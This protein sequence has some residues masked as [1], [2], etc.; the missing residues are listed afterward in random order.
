MPSP[1]K[2]CARQTP[3]AAASETRR[4]V[5]DP[6]P[7]PAATWLTMAK[8]ISALAKAE[9]A[10][11]TNDAACPKAASAIFMARVIPSA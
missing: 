4:P 9:T 6:G 2:S 10:N 8:S 3:L 1:G 5:N 11:G 7:R